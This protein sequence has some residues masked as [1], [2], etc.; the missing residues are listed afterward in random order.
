MRPSEIDLAFPFSWNRHS[1]RK[2]PLNLQAVLGGG[3]C[4]RWRQDAFGVWWGTVENC[5]IALWQPDGSPYGDLF[6]QT[7]PEPDRWEVVEYY[8]QLHI[9]LEALYRDWSQIDPRVASI[10]QA[11]PGVRVLRQPPVECLF[12]F[13]CASCNT[14]TK[15][16]RSVTHLAQKYGRKIATG[17][18]EPAE[19]VAFPTVEALAEV[20]E[21]V[22]LEG[23]WG[24]RAVFVREAARQILLKPSAWLE[25]LRELPHKE[26]REALQ[27]LP[28]IGPKVADC[29]C[30]FALDKSEAVPVDT[31]IYRLGVQ[32]FLPHLAGRSLT[33]LRY[34]EIAEVFRRRFGPYA[35]WAQQALFYASVQRLPRRLTAC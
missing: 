33:P 3:Q 4:F 20:D 17:L 34:E 31:H 23:L 1:C 32:L 16:E 2:T 14:I 28:G 7:F 10:L 6:W 21:E 30:L 25:S 26:A 24:Y 8:L 18:A 9:D 5:G 35:G 12:A 27:D 15:I 13:L 29:I 22:L 11:A 19:L